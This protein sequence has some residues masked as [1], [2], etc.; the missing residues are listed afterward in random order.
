MER[1][2]PE[3][4]PDPLA[5]SVTE[6]NTKLRRKAPRAN[7][8][9]LLSSSP[10]K[11]SRKQD[12]GGIELPSPTKSM[13]M[14][15]GRSGTASP[16]RI[17][18]TVQAEPGTDSDNQESPT[19]KHVTRTKTITVPLKDPDASSPVKRRGRPRKSDVG[20]KPKRAGTPV[21]RP[22]SRARSSSIGAPEQDSVGANVGIS[23][24]K[25]RGRPRKTVQPSS[26]D[27][28]TLAV[29]APEVQDR[30]HTPSS[31]GSS[32]VVPSLRQDSQASSVGD[33]EEAMVFTPP[34]NSL[35]SQVRTRKGTPAAR[36]SVIEI[37][38]DDE[39]SLQ[40]PSS[41][42][43]DAPVFHREIEDLVSQ[44]DDS[45]AMSGYAAFD[46]PAVDDD[47]DD[48][49]DDLQE[50]TNFAFDEGTTRMPDDPT[51][52][53]S[54]NFSMVS[55]DSLPSNGGLGSPPYPQTRAPAPK[56]TNSRIR[57][58]NLQAP[59]QLRRSILSPDIEAHSLP[60]S[61]QAATT[62]QPAARAI[63]PPQ[64]APRQITPVID[65][66]SPSNPPD[67][68]PKEPSPPKTE[69]PRLGYVVR[70]GVALQGLVE[71]NRLTPQTSSARKEQP[72]RLDDLFRGSSEDQEDYSLPQPP[73]APESDVQY[74][75]LAA[76]ETNAQ[77]VSPARS[78]AESPAE[79]EDEMSWRA[80][81][82]PAHNIT[83]EEGRFLTV[84]NER[85]EEMRGT[86]IS[87]VAG[88]E[89]EPMQTD[90]YY[91]IWQEEASRSSDNLENPTSEEVQKET[92]PMLQEVLAEDASARPPR[93]KLP[94]TWR[95]K[96]LND[97]QYS[98]EAEE[99]DN[100]IAETL[101][102]TADKPATPLLAKG[103]GRAA[104]SYVAEEQYVEDVESDAASD[105]SGMFFQTH[106]P[107]IFNKKRSA[108]LRKKS[109]EKKELSQLIRDGGSFVP[110]SSSPA[111]A[112]TPAATR[113]NPFKDTPPLFTPHK[114]LPVKSSPLRQ[115]LNT[116]SPVDLISAR[117]G[118]NSGLP[119][120]PSS[121][122]HTQV[123][124]E[125]M[126]STASD[127]LQFRVEM[128]GAT[129]SSIR[130]VR[131][132]ADGYLEAYEPQ[133]RSLGE[134]E[135]VTE[136]SRSW[137]QE[138]TMMPSSPPL[139]KHTFEES[140]SSPPK[141]KYSNLFSS[142]LG[143]ATSPSSV[144]ERNHIL[145][146]SNRATAASS[147]SS[148]S[149]GPRSVRR[150]PAVAV[151]PPAEEIPQPS[152]GIMSRLTSSLWSALGSPAPPPP[153]PVTSQFHH[154][155]KVEPWTKTHYKTLD[156]LYQLHKKTPT[157]FA[158]SSTPTTSNTNNTLL[159]HFL[160]THKK[161]FVGAKYMA[162]GYSI[163]MNESLIALC[164]VYMQ[165]MTLKDVWEY[166]KVAG[167]AIQ[168]GDC[169]PGVHGEPIEATE[170]VRR[171]ASVIMGEQLRK[172]EKRGRTVVKRGGMSI[173]W[174]TE[175]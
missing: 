142:E 43:E 42:D 172:D 78:P 1:S 85:G 11:L 23:P 56:S 109:A 129:D 128:I 141:R 75:A 44:E 158:P 82:P 135:E 89:K 63:S 156:A 164:A 98:D 4:S 161:P 149:V 58:E 152:S 2:D 126:A 45:A 163:T 81:T 157:L 27:A 154:L 165:L 79:S 25:P 6:N 150:K 24:K 143:A 40:T 18:V 91:D 77:L 3:S 20:A 76:S 16:W 13:V 175:R 138:T 174:P 41:T 155:P 114:N 146:S 171:L 65:S 119:L 170:V 35:N 111:P 64:I 74:P 49:D 134:I 29:K 52:L 136:P 118:E 120:G 59:S 99:A 57:G 86:E 97:S 117:D 73:Q 31:S 112:K 5:G 124:N 46:G 123:D 168:V 83:S 102:A 92:S 95:R 88:E 106:L 10:N 34:E 70:A 121:P 101:L 167:K 38:S 53:E 108:E 39:S 162:W 151:T 148:V 131:N 62:Q 103:K 69:T 122:F 54:E 21:R 105:D 17:K 173:E 15:T 107:S 159:T 130:R 104:E 9:P 71:S 137:N 68:A 90:D 12:V 28:E 26:E 153:H 133:D 60:E 87:V 7:K 115:E 50:A 67:V 100:I 19:V 66:R 32:S 8:T 140:M 94:K 93:A 116:E 139:L 14:S 147:R 110:E 37:S 160:S 33:Y 84:S 125:S 55:V 80:D 22:R 61:S 51:I 113:P 30:Q 169:N 144:A 36:G 145:S 132:E 166:E 96:S 47:D 127:Q 72:N 48:D